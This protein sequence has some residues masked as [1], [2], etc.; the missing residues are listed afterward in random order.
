VG[1]NLNTIQNNKR[2]IE[3][4]YFG[5]KFSV[6]YKTPAKEQSIKDSSEKGDTGALIDTLCEMLTYWDVYQ[7]EPDA[8]RNEPG[9]T[10][11]ITPATLGNLPSAFLGAILTACREDMI[12]KAKNGRK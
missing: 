6:T 8:A 10:L 4:E 2:T 9:T 3:A 12:P 7:V 11:P 1:I 5:D